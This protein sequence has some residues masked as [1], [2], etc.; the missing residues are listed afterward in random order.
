MIYNS[1]T[2]FIK[3]MKHYYS[4]KVLKILNDQSI[5]KDLLF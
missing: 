2:L 4:N 5:S 1:H 3:F